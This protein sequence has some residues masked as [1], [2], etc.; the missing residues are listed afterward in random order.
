MQPSLPFP[1]TQQQS[2]GQRLSDAPLPEQSHPRAKNA[3]P[4]GAKGELRLWQKRVKLERKEYH[5][6]KVLKVTAFSA[7]GRATEGGNRYPNRKTSSGVAGGGEGLA[8]SGEEEDAQ[9]IQA[10]HQRAVGACCMSCRGR[11]ALRWFLTSHL[12]S[13]LEHIWS[14]A[15]HLLSSKRHLAHT[16]GSHVVNKN[17]AARGT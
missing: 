5:I 17:N 10:P 13:A 2:R 8:E 1:S 7:E 3:D 15:S 16:H 4:L 9:T 12:P 6:T 11:R 14:K